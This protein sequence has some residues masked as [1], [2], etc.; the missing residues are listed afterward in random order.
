MNPSAFPARAWCRAL[1]AATLA[2]AACAAQAQSTLAQFWEFDD[3][4]G[5]ALPAAAP[6]FELG[7]QWTAAIAGVATTGTGTLRL[8]SAATAVAY[9][10]APLNINEGGVFAATIRYTGWDIRNG[11]ASGST[12]PIWNFG[13]RS[14]AGTASSLVADVQLTALAGGIDVLVRDA[15]S[16][17]TAQR[18]QLP[19][20]LPGPLT[21]TLRL[22]RTVTPRTWRLS[23]QIDGGAGGTVGGNLGT[24]SSSRNVSHVFLGASGNFPNGGVNAPPEVD[25]IQV[26]YDELPV[27]FEPP[28]FD[29]PPKPSNLVTFVSGTLQ[30]STRPPVGG[31]ALLL[32]GGGTE[33]DAAF[34]Q[35]AYPVNNGGDI[36]VLRA[37]G[38]NGYQNYMYSE[39]VQQL[40]A[41]LQPLLQ[42]NSVMT[43][44]ADTRGKAN[45]DYVFDAVSKANLVWMAGGDQ[46]QYIAN[47]KG[48]RLAEAVRLAYQRGAVIGGT[49]AGM[50]VSGEWMYDPGA[51]TA[52]VSSE[53]VANPYRPSVIISTDLFGLP[54]GFNLV[55]EPHFA[56]RDRMGRL[57][58]FMARLRQD[59]RTSL[60]YGVALDEQTSLFIDRTGTGT[61]QRQ[62]AAGN[63]YVLREDR[64]GTQR[65]QV[66][67][68]LPLVYRNVL[69]SPLTTAGQ[70]FDFTR[71]QPGPGVATTLISVEG[72]LPPAPYVGTALPADRDDR[73]GRDPRGAPAPALEER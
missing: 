28:V 62:A 34:T 41:H 59:A 1:A 12:R 16:D 18:F 37:S 48:T 5:T 52:V 3:P 35:R 57:L 58:T 24:T 69:R 33:V 39:L 30:Q 38:G 70:T 51:Q 19:G 73:D 47:W 36:V 44:I 46:S 54:L 22:D 9:S 29:R 8:G 68:G 71:G 45:S 49:S 6:G 66:A 64:R 43:I 17:F 40:P 20:A 61:F 4:A 27:T 26:L 72:A 13:L 2:V 42:P 50:V 23:W 7:A 10:F 63:G 15:Q 21:M 60:V 32:M 11:A 14:A 56:N 65:V 67:P 25:R 53:A 31:P 55:P